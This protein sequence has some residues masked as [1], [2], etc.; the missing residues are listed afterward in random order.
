MVYIFWLCDNIPEQDLKYGQNRDLVVHL[1]TA[2]F[3]NFKFKCM[4]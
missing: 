2:Q 3:I 4:P 1:R